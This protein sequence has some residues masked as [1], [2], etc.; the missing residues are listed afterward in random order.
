MV[1]LGGHQGEVLGSQYSEGKSSREGRRSEGKIRAEGD[2]QRE[3]KKWMS[4]KFWM[5]KKGGDYSEGSSV[6]TRPKRAEHAEVRAGGRAAR[7]RI[8]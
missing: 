3:T 1:P 4:K 5:S 8:Q 6:E 7:V 2:S